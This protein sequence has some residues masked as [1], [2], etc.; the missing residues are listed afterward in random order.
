MKKALIV[1]DIKGWQNYH[2]TILRT[3][4]ENNITIVTAD[5]AREA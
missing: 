1:D 5:S 2:A 4:F 3:L